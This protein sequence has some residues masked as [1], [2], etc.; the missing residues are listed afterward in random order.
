MSEQNHVITNTEDLSFFPIK[1]YNIHNFYEEQLS[2]FWVASEIDVSKDRAEFNNLTE[3]EQKC[4]K[5]ILAFFS[6]A[7]GFVCENLMENFQKTFS[8]IK[9]QKHFYAV[10]NLIETIH[11]QTY[12]ILIE[13]FIENLEEKNDILNSVK[14]NPIIKEIG[15]WMLYWMSPSR[16]PIERLVAFCY[17]EGVMFQGSFA[18]I[19]WF[20]RKN[21][22]EGLTMSN[23]LISRDEGIHTRAGC[24][25]YHLLVDVIREH[26]GV[27]FNRV[28]DERIAEILVDGNTRI[29]EPWI[30]DALEVDLIGLSS[31]ELIQYVHSTTDNLSEMLCGKK[32]YNEKNPFDWMINLVTVTKTN[33]F[34]KKVTNYTKNTNEQYDFSKQDYF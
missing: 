12:G 25:L 10:Q 16:D 28:S 1:H 22:L 32:I 26:D 9:E 5:T 14:T 2:V 19:H 18:P 17:I 27:K 29:A 23:E 20:K 6:Q 30:K 34:E 3:A 31:K 15:D 33:F 7:D 13:T 4:I 11:N 21:V 24:E 8:F